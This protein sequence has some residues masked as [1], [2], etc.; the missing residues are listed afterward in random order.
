[1][2]TPGNTLPIN[3]AVIYQIKGLNMIVDRKLLLL[4]DQV[5]PYTEHEEFFKPNFP[6]GKLRE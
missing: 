6:F 1:M 4:G 5:R 3:T 2:Q